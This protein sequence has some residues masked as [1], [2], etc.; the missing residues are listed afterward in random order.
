M[1]GSCSSVY[2]EL[3]QGADVSRR[4]RQNGV[5]SF[6][7]RSSPRQLTPRI[8]IGLSA[9]LRLLREGHVDTSVLD[10]PSDRRL[11]EPQLWLVVGH[12]VPEINRYP[13][14]ARPRMGALKVSSN[15]GI[16]GAC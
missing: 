2:E 6:C 14:G 3:K 16:L 1:Y 5:G 10:R 4:Q 11:A 8:S 15:W 9:V 12:C 7:F 13:Y